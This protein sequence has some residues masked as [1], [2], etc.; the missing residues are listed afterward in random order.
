MST[1]GID[2]IMFGNEENGLGEYA[3]KMADHRM[4]I[5]MYGFTQSLNISVSAAL[6]LHHLVPKI[7][8]SE[9][10]WHLSDAEI[11]DLKYRWI[12]RIVKR[13]ALLEKR[14]LESLE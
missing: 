1:N 9:V 4:I 8:N 2:T 10:D 13:G 14:F 3:L 6:T 7:H 5:P 12:K 11:L